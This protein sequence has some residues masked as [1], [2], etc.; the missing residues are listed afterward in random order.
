M[1][2]WSK[3]RVEYGEGVE[4]SD[5][6]KGEEENCRECEEIGY[7]AES[8]SERLIWEE[9]GYRKEKGRQ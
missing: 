5:S 7:W 9:E 4:E 1:C 2:S 6:E 8:W 3:R